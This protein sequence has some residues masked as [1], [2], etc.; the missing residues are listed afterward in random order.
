MAS[1]I[2]GRQVR[3]NQYGLTV[4]RNAANLPQTTTG[5]L[6]SITGG[7]ILMTT[8]VGEVTTAIQATPNATKLQTV[9]VGG[10]G[11]VDLCA[12]VDIAG[13]SVGTLFGIT[14]TFANAGA[15]GSSV[16]H[17]NEVVVGN[18][19]VRLSTAGSA[20]GQM[21]WLVTYIPLDDGAVVTAV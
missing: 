19:F 10:T 18:G 20:T 16:P 8:I 7:R 3:I 4:V 12:T 13:I 21:K 14:G 9:N 11:L 17:S 5:N 2:S 15:F 1:G 6:F